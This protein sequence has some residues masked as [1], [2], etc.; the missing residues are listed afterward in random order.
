DNT[1][2]PA[3]STRA[4]RRPPTMAEVT[5][6]LDKHPDLPAGLREAILARA[7]VVNAQYEADQNGGAAASGS[8]TVSTLETTRSLDTKTLP[9]GTYLLKFIASDR[10]GNPIEALSAEA[11]SDP[12]VICNA[13]PALYLLK[14][15]TKVHAD[16]T[17]SL[18][19]TV[20]Q[21]MIAVTAV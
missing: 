12:F 6:E 21:K 8:A 2:K 9:D 14:A 1:A 17:V 11:V 4:A 18:E 5:A 3:P 7:R 15:A 10:A 16:H 19:G 13:L 20:L